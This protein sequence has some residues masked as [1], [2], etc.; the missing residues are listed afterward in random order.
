MYL[1]LAHKIG[2]EENRPS[3]QLN[4]VSRGV[5]VTDVILMSHGTGS[6]VN[7]NGSSSSLN[8]LHPPP[9]PAT[10]NLRDP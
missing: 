2:S 1:K 8:A 7:L 10:V 9:P 6:L 3:L 5:N 4:D